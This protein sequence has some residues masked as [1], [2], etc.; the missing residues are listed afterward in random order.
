MHALVL[1][2]LETLI[3]V[4]F[5]LWSVYT[6]WRTMLKG[7]VYNG[8]CPFKQCSSPTCIPH[9]LLALQQG[10]QQRLFPNVC[11][12]ENYADKYR[13]EPGYFRCS[14]VTTCKMLAEVRVVHVDILRDGTIDW[15]FGFE[16]CYLDNALCLRCSKALCFSS[17]DVYVKQCRSPKCRKMSEGVFKKYFRFC[18]SQY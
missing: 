18:V 15:T 10:W 8:K 7:T 16:M 6:G 17:S 13:I 9:L 1:I 11:F 3:V 4:I 2:L 5:W 14:V 12:G